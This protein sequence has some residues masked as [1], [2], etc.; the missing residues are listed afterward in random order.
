MIIWITLPKMWSLQF[1]LG[2][3]TLPDLNASVAKMALKLL[4]KTVSET[5]V[6]SKMD[7]IKRPGN[8]DM[9]TTPMLNSEIWGVLRSGVRSKEV[10]VQIIPTKPVKAIT[11]L[12]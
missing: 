9:L 3:E 7:K 4:Q 10:H 1:E 12:A 8:C 11:L 6:K 2:D 5:A